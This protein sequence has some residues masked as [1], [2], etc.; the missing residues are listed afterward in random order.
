[1][2]T[3]DK[4]DNHNLEAKLELRRRLLRE[5]K[6]FDSL[7]VVDCFSGSEVIWTT[8]S[9][10]FKIKEYLALDIKPKR[11]RIQI[12]SLR[13]LQN[14]KWT[15]N[16]IDLDAYGSPWA[17]WFEVLKRG[18]SCIVFLTVFSKPG[19][20]G[21]KISKRELELIGAEKLY[22]FIAPMLA[23][24][25]SATIF[26]ACL[27]EP[28]ARGFSIKSAYEAKNPG[29]NVRYFGIELVKQDNST[30]SKRKKSA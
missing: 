26:D 7:S 27:S 4:Q 15:H 14:Q 28:L 22:E 10:E 16:V 8:L 19:M 21:R 30:A 3:Q 23:K 17:H 25:I 13:Y 6:Q 11:G 2:M 12:D 29:G 1:M 18:R 24:S 20:L 9:K 5:Q